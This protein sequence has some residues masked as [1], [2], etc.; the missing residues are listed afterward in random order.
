M[1]SCAAGTL[2]CDFIEGIL[3]GLLV[4]G[5]ASLAALMLAA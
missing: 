3:A 2:S 5:I 1:G 4:L